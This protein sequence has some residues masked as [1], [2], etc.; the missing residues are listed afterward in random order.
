MREGEGGEARERSF[1]LRERNQQ[2]EEKKKIKQ[3]GEEE[4]TALEETPISSFI[5]KSS[6][7]QTAGLMAVC[8]DGWR[9][10]NGRPVCL[11]VQPGRRSA[12]MPT[13]VILMS[14]QRDF[15]QQ[16]V[17]G[18]TANLVSRLSAGRH[19]ARFHRTHTSHRAKIKSRE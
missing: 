2:D 3:P 7:C 1:C 12:D 4:P 9:Q 14:R 13:G 6:R 15:T 10:S 18:H 17:C 8:I 11:P 16:L 5:V 19:G